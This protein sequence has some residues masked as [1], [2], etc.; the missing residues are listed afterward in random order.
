VIATNRTLTGVVATAPVTG[1]RDLQVLLDGATSPA[2]ARVAGGLQ[3]TLAAQT[4]VFV[5]PTGR[6]LLVVG[7]P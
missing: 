3:V 7:T 1:S 6:R 4:R 5:Q 2:P